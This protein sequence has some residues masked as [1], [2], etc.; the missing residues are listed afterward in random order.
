MSF[1]QSIED[2]RDEGIYS[3]DDSQQG[4]WVNKYAPT[5]YTHLLSDE[6][7]RLYWLSWFFF[8]EKLF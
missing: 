3:E 2:T 6:V 7:W 4:L 8:N 1:D 5:R